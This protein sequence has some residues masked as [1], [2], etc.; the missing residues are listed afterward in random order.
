[1]IKPLEGRVK[2]DELPL[3]SPSSINLYITDPALWVLKH[4]YGETSEYNI[5][6]MRGT[7]IEDGINAKIEEGKDPVSVAIQNFGDMA[8]HWSDDELLESIE[9]QI[10]DWVKNGL[11][12]VLEIGTPDKIQ[13]E[14][15]GEHFG[16]PLRGFVDYTIGDKKI[17][18]KTATK[19]PKVS[20]RG[21][22]KGMLEAGKKA[23]LR[24]QTIYNL[25]SG[26][27]V[28][29]LYV[30]PEGSYLH[31]VT[32]DEFDEA[33]EDL[34]PAIEGMKKLLT[35]DINDVIVN[36]VPKWKTMKHSFFW[37]EPLRRL[38]DKLWKDHKPK[39]EDDEFI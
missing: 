20:S 4:F 8:F 9:Q 26:D 25:I 21:A 14:L 28:Y 2:P 33:M 22:R 11:E 38:A 36:S 15:R 37:D 32:P 16:V 5:H 7:A 27:P 12:A 35:M 1:M 6:A 39:G 17:D 34:V 24:Q 29:L 18:L 13:E 23:N 3:I 10:P 19:L 31:E 30:S